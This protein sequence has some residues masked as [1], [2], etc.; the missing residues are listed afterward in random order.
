MDRRPEQDFDVMHLYIMRESLDTDTVGSLLGVSTKQVCGTWI[1]V[2]LLLSK[3]SFE[4]VFA[5]PLLYFIRDTVT[6]LGL[7]YSVFC[8]LVVL[9]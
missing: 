2:R 1:F 5:V 4:R 9:F 7:S 6:L 3:V 8:V